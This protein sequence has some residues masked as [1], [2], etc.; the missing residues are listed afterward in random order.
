MSPTPPPL[1]PDLALLLAIAAK[2][3]SRGNL[4][5]VNAVCKHV[6]IH[7]FLKAQIP[8]PNPSHSVT[9]RSG[10]SPRR[11]KPF[12]SLRINL[13]RPSLPP[14]HHHPH[15]RPLLHL[16][17]LRTITIIR[18]PAPHHL[19]IHRQSAHLPNRPN[20][21]HLLLNYPRIRTGRRRRAVPHAP[22]VLR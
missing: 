14:R 8:S 4:K 10:S 22:N 7:P 20:P 15:S 2:A 1:D 11:T 19:H 13:N 6:S 17:L 9:T 18:F 16:S 3:G 12:R 5:W 21:P